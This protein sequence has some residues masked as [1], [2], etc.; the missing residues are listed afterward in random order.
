M[1]ARRGQGAHRDARAERGRRAGRRRC[2]CSSATTTF[3]IRSWSSTTAQL[4]LIPESARNRTRRG[5][6]LRR[7]PA[8][9]APGARAA[10]RRAPGRRHLLPLGASAGGCSPT[11]PPATA[12]ASTTSCTCSTPPSLLGEWQPHVRNP[13]KLRRALRAPGRR[14]LLAQR[15]AVPPG[16]DLRAALRRRPVD[17]PRA[18]P[19]PG[20]L[21]R[22][23][24]GAHPARGR[25]RP[26]RPAHRQPRRRPDRGRRLARRRRI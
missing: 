22:A 3:R 11:A 23:P 1:R 21:R 20:R 6:P 25:Q 26:A 7:L 16:A 15:R 19:D 12:A 9:L 10:R 13:V 5:L 14:A 8:A 18:A 17:Q 24:G 4:Y 2:A